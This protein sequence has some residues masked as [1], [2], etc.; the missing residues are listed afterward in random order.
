MTSTPNPLRAVLTEI[1][2]TIAG[3]SRSLDMGFENVRRMVLGLP[4]QLSPS[5]KMAL[6]T[7]QGWT[8][9]QC[10]ELDIAYQQWRANK[11]A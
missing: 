5:L 8:I 6:M 11:D 2:P 4:K 1:A 7:H 9:E 10:N 3:A